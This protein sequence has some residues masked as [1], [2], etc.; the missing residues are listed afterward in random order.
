METIQL[1]REIFAVFIEGRDDERNLCRKWGWKNVTKKSLRT[2]KFFSHAS[3]SWNKSILVSI[4]VFILDS[5]SIDYSDFCVFTKSVQSLV[6]KFFGSSLMT[7]RT[8]LTNS[9]LLLSRYCTLSTRT[10]STSG[11]CRVKVKVD[12]VVFWEIKTKKK[13]VQILLRSHFSA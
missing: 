5:N 3:F 2:E 6:V 10:H 9:S 4:F 13:K 1:K 12:I 11:D 8:L 7:R